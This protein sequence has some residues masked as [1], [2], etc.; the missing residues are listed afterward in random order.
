M[1]G[2][3]TFLAMRLRASSGFTLLEVIVISVIV[4]ILAAIAAP[5]FL[6]YLSRQE[7][8]AARDEVLQ[9]LRE[10]QSE[11]KRRQQTV[12]FSMTTITIVNPNTSEE[13]QVLATAVHLL[14]DVPEDGF[15][16][17]PD[18]FPYQTLATND[19]IQL[20]V[21]NTPS[22]VSEGSNVGVRFNSRGEPQE[23]GRITLQLEGAPIQRCV[24]ISTLLGALR[25]AEDADCD[26]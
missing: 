21:A 2:L 20:S 13:Q 19:A 24:I 9:G 18:S 5:S 16:P 7:L 11:A 3:R 17:A 1:K 10:A 15:I 14:G 23:L 12:Q 22:T 4:G 6:G 25:T 26:L 8:N